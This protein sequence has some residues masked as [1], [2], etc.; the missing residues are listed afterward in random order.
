MNDARLW[1][2]GALGAV[3]A[4]GPSAHAAGDPT[5]GEWMT[6]GG[7][8]KVRVAPC[9][10][11]PALACGT[12][13]WLKPPANAPAGPLHDANN[14]NPALRTR[15]LQGILIVSDFHREAPGRWG[16]GKIYD[17]NDGKTYR[18]KMNAAPDG[19]LRV[20]G[21]VAIFCKEQTWTKA[22]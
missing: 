6:A 13:V 21:C 9:A 11:D 1:A 4:V 2:A 16:D 20:S 12:L 7:S 18:S 8:G 10:S 5:F 14:P 19:T 3:L 15:L 17:P 22:Q